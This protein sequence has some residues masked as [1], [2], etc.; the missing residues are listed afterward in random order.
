MSE[1]K[2]KLKKNVNHFAY[3]IKRMKECAKCQSIE[4]QRDRKFPKK[5]SQCMNIYRICCTK[6]MFHPREE[7]CV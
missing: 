3:K 2:K 4:I 7:D 6:W 1:M 5:N